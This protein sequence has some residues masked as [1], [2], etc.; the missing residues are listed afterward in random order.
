MIKFGFSCIFLVKHVIKRIWNK[1]SFLTVLWFISPN[2][3]YTTRFINLYEM[4]SHFGSY[5]YVFGK[6]G[7]YLLILIRGR[8]CGVILALL[9]VQLLHANLVPIRIEPWIQENTCHHLTYSTE[10][11]S[12]CENRK[13]YVI[14]WC[15][16]L[17]QCQTVK[18]GKY[19]SSFDVLNWNSVKLWKQENICHHLMFSTETVSNSENGKICVIIW[20]IQPKQCQT[21]KTG[22]YM[23]SFDVL[24]WN[25]VKLWK[26]GN[27]CH[28][29]MFSTE[30]VSNSENGKI[31]VI[32]WRTKLKQR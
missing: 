30:T 29:M 24:N 20:H 27:I 6:H 22:K 3:K 26:Q 10:T 7:Q 11:V 32:I 28:H 1:F 25:S 4:K 2:A 8:V 13:I 15:S 12:N 23:S 21:V 17:K 9:T 14:I 18:T 16:Q 31:C 5:I 19:M